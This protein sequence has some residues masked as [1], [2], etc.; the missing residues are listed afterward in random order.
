MHIAAVGTVGLRSGAM[1]VGHMF[2]RNRRARSG[3]S[4]RGHVTGRPVIVPTMV[5]TP[6]PAPRP[7]A[8]RY[9]RMSSRH[10][11]RS[12]LHRRLVS[13]CIRILYHLFHHHVDQCVHRL[14]LRATCTWDV[15]R[16]PL[17]GI[18]L[19]D[20]GRDLRSQ[21]HKTQILRVTPLAAAQGA[22]S[23]ADGMP[24]A[25]DATDRETWSKDYYLS[26]FDFKL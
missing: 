2:E 1:L 4:R 20:G 19:A 7:G 26:V 8:H 10:P 16:A 21:V 6:L 14:R 5:D 13:G 17:L 15:H 18:K 23:T 3:V 24:M 9:T 11:S 12:L 25:G 22:G